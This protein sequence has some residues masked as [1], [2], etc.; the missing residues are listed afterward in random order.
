MPEMPKVKRDEK[1]GLTH[2]N[3]SYLSA[4]IFVA[5]EMGEKLARSKVLQ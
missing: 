4:S 3:L 2:Q 5:K 1:S